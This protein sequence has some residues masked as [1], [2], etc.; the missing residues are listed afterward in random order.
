MGSTPQP[1]DPQDPEL[2]ELEATA[3]VVVRGV[4]ATADLENF[5]DRA[6]ATLARELERRGLTP[7]GHAIAYSSRPPAET[8]DLAVGFPVA[9]RLDERGEVGAGSD[10]EIT[11][12]TLPGGRAAVVVHAGGYDSLAQA[13]D[14]LER[15]I[16]EQGLTPA[17]QSWEVYLTEP[18]PDGDPADNRTRLVQPVTA[19]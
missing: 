14:D 12:L 5:F 9:S 13:W 11:A 1:A 7:S 10:G 15:W 19:D 4:V 17:L 18:T 2:V 16:R 6:F 3:A 8:S